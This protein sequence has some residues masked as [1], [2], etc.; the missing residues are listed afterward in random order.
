[1]KKVSY[2]E[3]GLYYYVQRSSSISNNQTEKVRDIF[4]I[5]DKLIKHYKDEK[6]YN[7]YNDVIEYLHIRYFLGSS[8]LRI[9]GINDKALRKSI[10][11]ENW[12]I[13]NNRY[14]Q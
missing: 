5:F 6:I 7:K 13:L 2:V 11:N 9:L 4:A 3:K 1:V 14:P 10:L 12:Q 8:F